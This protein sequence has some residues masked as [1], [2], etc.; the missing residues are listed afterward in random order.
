MNKF[1]PGFIA[2]KEIRDFYFI[3][4]L[5]EALSSLFV[6]RSSPESRRKIVRNFIYFINL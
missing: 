4:P 6:D 1:V 2:K 5:A 3:G